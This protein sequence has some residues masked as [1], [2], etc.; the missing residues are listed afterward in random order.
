MR[1]RE[2]EVR[3]GVAAFDVGVLDLIIN[4]LLHAFNVFLELLHALLL[5]AQLSDHAV[6]GLLGFSLFF[7][8]EAGTAFLEADVAEGSGGAARHFDFGL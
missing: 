2:R 6:V 7:S 8:L 3:D 4:Q 1:L 5:L